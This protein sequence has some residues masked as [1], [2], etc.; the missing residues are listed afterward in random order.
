MFPQDPCIRI[1]WPIFK[2][3]YFLGSMLNLINQTFSIWGPQLV[4]PRA[5]FFAL[6][7]WCS[8]NWSYKVSEI[9]PRLAVW[10]A[11]TIPA[12][13]SLISSNQA[14]DKS[15]LWL[16]PK[17]YFCKP[18]MVIYC[19]PDSTAGSFWQIKIKHPPGTPC[20]N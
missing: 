10:K 20:I 16:V 12:L 3:A 14:V 11:I 19:L 4:V 7:W 18:L 5:Y 1:T 13:L 8:E 17:L 2:N 15:A 9:K 6:T